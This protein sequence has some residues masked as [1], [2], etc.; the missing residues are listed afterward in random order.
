MYSIGDK[1]LFVLTSKGEMPWSAFRGAAE[2]LAAGEF[3]EAAGD[4]LALGAGNTRLARYQALLS[5]E[6][7]G[8]CDSDVSGGPAEVVRA[9]A[10][11]VRLPL[12]GLPQAVL[13]GARSERTLADLN[14][15]AQR[16]PDIEVRAEAQAH[17]PFAPSRIFVRTPT[18]PGLE[19]LA[20]ALAIPIAGGP[21]AWAMVSCAASIQE[22]RDS[23]SWENDDGLNW[24]RRD[25]NPDELRF[26]LPNRDAH[27]AL[28][29]MTNPVNNTRT[30]FYTSGGR[31]SRVD[32]YW[33]RY[34]VM[35]DLDKRVL[36]YDP[37]R[38]KFALPATLPPPKL[39]ER[40]LVLCSGFTPRVVDAPAGGIAGSSRLRIYSTVPKQVA[41]L[42]AEKLGQRLVQYQFAE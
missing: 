36:F 23:L 33:A 40:A 42:A 41:S 13:A 17:D 12:G 28:R 27:P 1:L 25:F 21:P 29:S 16:I 2:S 18:I 35:Q 14:Q 39:I 31:R 24:E 3:S 32:R 37:Q 22:Y 9:P 30:H 20:T 6:S 19:E 34:M 7:L 26:T 10:C 38:C 4:S 11:L 5:L 8:H 15:A